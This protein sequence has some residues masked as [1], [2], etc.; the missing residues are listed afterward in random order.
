MAEIGYDGDELVV[1]LTAFE[2]A[3]SLH[4]DVRVRAED[5]Q[6]IDVVDDAMAAVRGLR[7]PGTGI[8]RLVA[9]GTYRRRGAKQFAVVHHDTRRG[10]RIRLAPQA[11]GLSELIVGCAEPDA[12]VARLDA[13]RGS[14]GEDPAPPP[15]SSR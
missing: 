15:P 5:V 6:D 10:V 11:D 2:K 1:R 13:A 4:G 7:A 8:P 9:V 14:P 12:V 3:E